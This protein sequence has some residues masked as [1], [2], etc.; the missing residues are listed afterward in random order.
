MLRRSRG[1]P[2]GRRWSEL[3]FAAFEPWRPRLPSPH[4]TC[5]ADSHLIR[6]IVTRALWR[7]R[8]RPWRRPTEWPLKPHGNGSTRRHAKGLEAR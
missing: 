1:T 4:D 6:R 8:L 5:L 2:A 3:R 7:E